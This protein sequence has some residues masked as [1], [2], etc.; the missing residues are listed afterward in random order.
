MSM[1]AAARIRGR[2]ELSSEAG[3]VWL[4][5]PAD[6]AA[7][8]LRRA[9]DV[10]P[11]TPDTFLDELVGLT[12]S[13]DSGAGL[14]A[15]QFRALPAAI[16]SAIVGTLLRRHAGA[17][18]EA[19]LP[20]APGESDAAF[21]LR[22]WRLAHPKSAAAEAPIPT[23]DAPDSDAPAHDT[24]PALI[25]AGLIA[26]QMQAAEPAAPPIIESRASRRP[27]SRAALMLATMACLLAIATLGVSMT[28]LLRQDGVNQAMMRDVR[29]Q[30]DQ[31]MAASKADAA[32]I[33]A[34]T[35]EVRSLHAGTTVQ[36]GAT[37]PSAT[38]P[39]ADVPPLRS[40]QASLRPRAR[41]HA[42][43]PIYPARESPI[44]PTE[45]GPIYPAKVSERERPSDE[46][47]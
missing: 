10:F 11:F 29:Q 23:P 16:K 18:L 34:L 31:M 43:P 41:A 6:G 44:Y 14:T 24:A 42:Q 28:M 38:A 8:E 32:A 13:D 20:R 21:L 33:A 12:V 40:R 30:Q 46:F 37:I 25:A 3:G 17:D 45:A 4:H 26:P 2:I 27:S 9:D 39:G 36:S 22:V 15:D 7:A 5:E 19:A 47:P 1:T 35:A